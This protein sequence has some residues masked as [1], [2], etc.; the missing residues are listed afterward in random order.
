MTK[1]PAVQNQVS[2][3]RQPGRL[4]QTLEA[5]LDDIGRRVGAWDF[6]NLLGLTVF[7]LGFSKVI[8]PFGQM[9]HETGV[10]LPEHTNRLLWLGQ[11]P[12]AHLAAWLLVFGMIHKLL[13][14]RDQ[15][16]TRTDPLIVIGIIAVVL[17]VPALFLPLIGLTNKL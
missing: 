6:A 2:V 9:F 7:V 8:Q 3:H 15:A 13:P 11:T 1:P 10:M 4:R 16:R 14:G 17:A 5:T 12:V